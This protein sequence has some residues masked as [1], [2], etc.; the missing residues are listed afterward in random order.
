M[1]KDKGPKLEIRHA[2]LRD[3]AG[4]VELSRRV[5]PEEVPYTQGQ[6]SGQINAFRDG[7]FVAIYDGEIVGYAAST[8]MA[9][10]RVMTPHTWSEITGGGYASQHNGNGDWLYG[11][12]V[13][14]HPERRRLRI[15]KRLYQARERL[16]I[17]L[18]MKGIAFGGRIPG[19]RRNRKQYPDPGSYLE[20]VKTGDLKDTVINFQMRNGFEPVRAL[21]GYAPDDLPSGGHAAL[22]IWRNAYHDPDSAE[23]PLT[24]ADPDVV[25]VASVQ[26]YARTLRDRRSFSRRSTISPTLPLNTGPISSSFPSISR[27][28]SCRA[29]MRNCRPSARS[30]GRRITRRRS[31][32]GFAT[33]RWRGPSTSSVAATRHRPRTATFTT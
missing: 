25:R 6:V 12:E 18:G 11:M 23:Q 16:C 3:I 20:A 26:L 19:F 29:K 2:C 30:N 13:M 4:I 22:M 15:G 32:N 9:E 27:S 10:H 28:S 33:W 7:T 21:P 1:A 8:I 17:D 24:R 5:Y 31:S 14:V